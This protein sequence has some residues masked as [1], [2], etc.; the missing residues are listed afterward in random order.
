MTKDTIPMSVPENCWPPLGWNDVTEFTSF[1]KK[2]GVWGNNEYMKANLPKV[3]ERVAI[4]G[5]AFP[6]AELV[7]ALNMLYVTDAE[8][9]ADIVNT[10]EALY[11]MTIGEITESKALEVAIDNAKM[12]VR[13][14]NG[15]VHRST[16]RYANNIDGKLI[17]ANSIEGLKL[18][19]VCKPT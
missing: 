5:E 19:G 8:G 10:C 7:R 15:T 14:N 4:A 2:W 3:I 13:N 11:K 1:Y 16:C 18:C 17:N 9:L 12:Y 6:E